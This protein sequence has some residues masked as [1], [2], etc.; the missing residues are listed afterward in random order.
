MLRNKV[1]L[2]EIARSVS[3]D[4]MSITHTAIGNLKENAGI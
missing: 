2:R 1:S 3:S 4:E